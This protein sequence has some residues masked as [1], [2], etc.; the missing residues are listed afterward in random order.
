MPNN[1]D[2][3]GTGTLNEVLLHMTGRAIHFRV[4]KLVKNTCL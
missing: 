1:S 2:E 4:R 3:I